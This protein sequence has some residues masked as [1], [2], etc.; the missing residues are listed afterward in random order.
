M[1]NTPILLHDHNEFQNEAIFLKGIDI[2]KNIVIS[3][4]SVAK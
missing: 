4:G 1:N 3:L 2:F